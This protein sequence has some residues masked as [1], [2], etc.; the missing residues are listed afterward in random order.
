MVP[1]GMFLESQGQGKHFF[2]QLCGHKMLSTRFLDG[3][4]HG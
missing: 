4:A 1:C 2:K 3:G